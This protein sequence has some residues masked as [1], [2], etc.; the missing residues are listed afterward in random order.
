MGLHFLSEVKLFVYKNKVTK[1]AFL[2]FFIQVI[3]NFTIKLMKFVYMLV[4]R[5]KN[6]YFYYKKINDLPF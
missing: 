2:I 3:Y 4:N 1:I 5:M 6:D